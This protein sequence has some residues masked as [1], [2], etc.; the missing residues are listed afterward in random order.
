MH[1]A[2]QQPLARDK[3]PRIEVMRGRCSRSGRLRISTVETGVVDHLGLTARARPG[4]ESNSP[5]WWNRVK[6]LKKILD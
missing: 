2:L 6:L 3:K 4:V 5:S 1:S